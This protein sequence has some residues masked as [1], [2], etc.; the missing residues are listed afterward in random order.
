[1]KDISHEYYEPIR[2]LIHAAEGPLQTGRC[3]EESRNYKPA[4]FGRKILR[5]ESGKSLRFTFLKAAILKGRLNLNSAP[6]FC[7]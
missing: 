7:V 3:V 5:D 6:F 1:M 4:N 2:A